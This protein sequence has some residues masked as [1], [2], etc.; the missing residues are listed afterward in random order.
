MS[1]FHCNSH[2]VRN[3]SEDA[4]APF[5]EAR[6]TFDTKFSKIY[7]TVTKQSNEI[8]YTWTEMYTFEDCFLFFADY[9]NEN[10]KS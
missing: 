2:V 6:A 4:L 5:S 9:N 10:L 8:V 3:I 7:L 1:P